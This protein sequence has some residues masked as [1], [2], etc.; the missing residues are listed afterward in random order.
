VRREGT[1]L[2][3]DTAI[4]RDVVIVS[5]TPENL[6]TARAF[7]VADVP[8]LSRV[9]RVDSARATIWVEPAT[10]PNLVDLGRS[11]TASELNLLRNAIVAL[12]R[13]GA[14]HGALSPSTIHVDSRRGLNVEYPSNVGVTATTD[15]DWTALSLLG[16]DLE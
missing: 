5:A 6:R 11:L 9:F 13:A 4:D 2:C 16:G 12:H 3:R 15:D 14:A 8:T 7:A 1:S 10:G